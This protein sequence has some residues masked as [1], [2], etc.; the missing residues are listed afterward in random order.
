MGTFGSTLTLMFPK[1][2]ND[3][4]HLKPKELGHFTSRL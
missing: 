3:T 4:N 2:L 1:F